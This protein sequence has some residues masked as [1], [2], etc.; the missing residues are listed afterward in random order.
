MNTM[1][2]MKNVRLLVINS[3]RM[4]NCEII[5][6]VLDRGAYVFMCLG[7]ECLCICVCV[8]V[9]VVWDRFPMYTYV[10]GCGSYLSMG[11]GESAYLFMF[12]SAFLCDTRL[13]ILY[14]E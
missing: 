4:L 11:F 1:D 8:C 9:C 7:L 2:T 10:L 6:H 3:P 13:E 5:L 12:G 14:V